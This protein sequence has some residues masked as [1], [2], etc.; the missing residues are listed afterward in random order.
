[1]STVTISIRV[2]EHLK[3]ELAKSAK[4]SNKSVNAEISSRLE[5]SFSPQRKRGNQVVDALQLNEVVRIRSTSTSA[6]ATR[7]INLCRELDVEKVVF[8]ARNDVLNGMV[9]VVVLHTQYATF[10]LDSSK[11]NMAREPRIFEVQD[12]FRNLDEIGLLEVSHF[13][14]SPLEETSHLP[15]DE[16]LEK[17]LLSGSVI[18]MKNLSDFLN[19]LCEHQ[20]FVEEEFKS[21]SKTTKKSY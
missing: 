12:I 7:L 6:D 16:A 18:R 5:A 21:N 2:P 9:M 14:N 10:L 13:L 19:I 4:K 20:K 15:P 3:N 11:L 17:I 1:M 8:G